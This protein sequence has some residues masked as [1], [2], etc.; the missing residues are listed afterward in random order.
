GILTQLC[1]ARPEPRNL[2][3]FPEWLTIRWHTRPRDWS[4]AARAMMGTATRRLG[5]ELVAAVAI[6]ALLGLGGLALFER[7]RRE[8]LFNQLVIAHAGELPNRMR[9]FQ[10]YLDP[11]RT[12]LE[13]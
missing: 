11:Y 5:L 12:R 8:A 2:P 4:P 3:S 6:L 1:T 10:P 7:Q 9:E 13:R